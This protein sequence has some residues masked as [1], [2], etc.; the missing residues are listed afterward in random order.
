[1]GW[2]TDYSYRQFFS[3]L[4]KATRTS[5]GLISLCGLFVGLCYFP[6]WFSY[7]FGRALS[8]AISWFIIVSM[9]IF[10]GV[11]LWQKRKSLA[12][13]RASEADKTIGHAL[14]LT[15][16]LAY[17]WCR[18]ALWSQALIWLTI[19]LGIIISTWGLT[20]FQR[21]ALSS[22][23][24]C[25][26]VYPR[27]GILSRATWDFFVPTYALENWMA[28]GTTVALQGIGFQALAEGRF[29]AFPQGKVEVGW[30]C[31]GLDMAITVAIAG[32]FLGLI[33]RQTFS[34]IAKFMTIGVLM[35]LL[36]N[37]PRLMLVSIAYVYWG[38]GWFNFWHG[39]WGGQVF[40]ALLFT[41]YYYSVIYLTKPAKSST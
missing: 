21:H 13:Y 25:L 1:M 2:T 5:H 3:Q 31:N 7:L 28:Q 18:F 37:L 23:F 6:A 8:G 19:L 40:S 10:V 39:F 17:P 22:M 29:I 33:F 34:E 15:S 36:A 9:L 4:F 27:L 11:E 20:F 24:L 30:G 38:Q 35:A 16:V 14:I 12:R 32:L 26:T 41:L